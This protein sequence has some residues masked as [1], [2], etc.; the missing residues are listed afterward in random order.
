MLQA[1]V[2]KDSRF[3]PIT[4]CSGVAFFKE[5][6]TPVPL[7]FEIEAK[8]CEFL[9]TKDFEDKPPKVTE[10]IIEKEVEPEVEEKPETIND[11]SNATEGAISL[12]REMKV[13][14]SWITGTGKGGKII[15]EDIKDYLAQKAK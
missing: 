13:R 15:V 5:T 6:W 9:E 2:K 3:A 7:G 8:A 10:P 4:S 14:L 12:A 1:K 11:A